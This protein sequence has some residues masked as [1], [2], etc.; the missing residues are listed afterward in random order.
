MLYGRDK[1]LAVLATMVERARSGHGAAVVV[2]GEPGI[3]K[4]ALLRDFASRVSG[5]RVLRAAGVEPESDIGYATLHQLLLPVLDRADRLPAPQSA[6]L[7]VVFGLAAGSEPDRFLVGLATLSLLSEL[8]GEHPVVCVVDDI[9]WSDRLSKDVLRFV[10]RRIDTEPIVLVLASRTNERPPLGLPGVLDMPLH[11]LDREAAKRLLAERTDIRLSTDRQDAIVDATAGN[12][13][14]LLELPSAVVRDGASVSRQ[15]ILSDGLRAAFLTRVRRHTRPI[16]RLLLLIAAAG[17]LRREVLTHAAAE[18]DAASVE[19]LDVL[20]DLVETGAERIALRHPLILSA[21]Y[22]SATTSDRRDAHRA[23]AA[24][25]HTVT[26]ESD[27]SVWHLGQATDGPDDEVAEQLDRMARKVVRTSSATAAALFARA[28]ELSTEGPH[29]L[30]RC[31]ESALAHWNSGDA[32]HARSMLEFLDRQEQLDGTLRRDIAWLRASMELHTGIPADVVV[33]LRSPI[34]EA[35]ENS[36]RQ[37]IPL[38]MLFGEAGFHA[39]QFTAWSQ[40]VDVAERVPASGSDMHDALLGLFRGVCRVW[41]GE[42]DGLSPEDKD[43]V[44]TLTDPAMLCWA[45]GMMWSLGE[46]ERGRHLNR[47]AVLHARRTGAVSLLVWALEREALGNIVGGEFRAAETSAQEGCQLAEEIGQTN[48]SVCHRS[49]LALLA[50]FRGH[51]Q[52]ARDLAHEVLAEAT[53]RRLA[54]V[55]ATARRALAVLDLAAGHPGAAL[56]NL[57][58]GADPVHPGVVQVYIPDLVEAAVKAGRPDVATRSLKPLARWAESVNSPETNALVA[59]CRALLAEPDTAEGEFRRALVLHE[60]GDQPMEYARTQLLF[61]EYLRRQRRRAQARVP[62]RAAYDTFRSLGAM[63]WAERACSELRAAGE[64]VE[65]VSVAI[66]TDVLTPQEIRIVTA[67]VEGATNREI[68]AQ[69]FLSTR[70]ID[71]HLRKIFTKLGVRSRHELIRI[72]LTE[73]GHH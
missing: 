20:D 38:L 73:F 31:F 28:G 11:G 50:A 21:V 25:M 65:P 18:F 71:Y 3:G 62:L 64:N 70:T 44:E 24:A 27:R 8:A 72:T 33:M 58:P 43:I 16:Q 30:R 41:R 32:D 46:R 17:H 5:V 40:L 4:S 23:L 57:L 22:Q 39:N 61:G 9:H 59:R 66:R 47:M 55:I 52:R 26:G 63:G 49:L 37:A 1:E 19:E 69:M 68:A 2:R 7:E 10:A 67:V 54:F 45:G 51:E 48:A 14:A 35:L 13:L 6:A 12:P 15:V 56:A 60:R 34:A 42:P 29:R 53:P 36:P